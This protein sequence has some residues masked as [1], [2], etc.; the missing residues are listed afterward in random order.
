MEFI[1]EYK[2]NEFGELECCEIC[3]SEAPLCEFDHYNPRK[4]IETPTV[5]LCEICSGTLLGSEIQHN[6]DL[7]PKAL[8]QALNLLLRKLNDLKIE[9]IK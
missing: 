7:S 1:Y 8:T 2:K 6:N 3:C 4:K 5:F 9:K